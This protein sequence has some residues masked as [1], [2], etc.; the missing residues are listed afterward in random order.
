MIPIP[1][2]R[3]SKYRNVKTVVKGITFDSK[4]E[5]VRWLALRAM[6]KAGRIADLKRQVKFEI[7]C[8][9]DSIHVCDYVADFQY[10]DVTRDDL[11]VEDVKGFRT[12]VYI[13]KKKLMLAVH[14]IAIVEPK[15]CVDRKGLNKADMRV[16]MLFRSD[17]PLTAQ[18]E[19][20]YQRLSVWL[21]WA[22]KSLDPATI[23]NY[24]D[25]DL[26]V[27]WLNHQEDDARHAQ[28]DADR[29]A[30]EAI[31][32]AAL[33]KLSNEERDALGIR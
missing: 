8:G 28:E 17:G 23:Q 7:V 18:E 6:Q 25:I 30:R 4:A 12:Q 11:V 32:A 1:L 3:Q 5:A 31:K 21:C 9:Q 2:K 13:L 20:P 29:A 26:R 16:R 10:L 24:A 22:L 15:A 33:A 19:Y 14:G 27:W